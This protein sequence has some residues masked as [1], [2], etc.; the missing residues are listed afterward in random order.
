MLRNI[1]SP[2]I[3]ISKNEWLIF[4]A[5]VYNKNDYQNYDVKILKTNFNLDRIQTL[6][7]NLS[8][9]NLFELY[10]LRENYK[11][12]NYSLTEVELQ[13]LKLASLPLYLLLV[14]IFASLIMLRV[15]RLEN[16]TFKI[17]LGL[18]FSVIIYYVNNFFFV[19]GKTEKIPLLASTFL[20]LLIFILLNSIMITKIN[21]K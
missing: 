19:L 8:S 16:S 6:Y 12:L 5:K 1:K 9:L 7:S 14:S 2:K 13:L 20:P 18:F 4:D 21:E 3:D 11:K 15:K 10:E 17:A